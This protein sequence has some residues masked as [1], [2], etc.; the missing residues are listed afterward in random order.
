MFHGHG[1]MATATVIAAILAFS[2]AIV[3]AQIIGLLS[4]DRLSLL[5]VRGTGA[6]PLSMGG[7]Y[8]AVSDDA[9]AVFYNPAGLTQIGDRELSFGIHHAQSG[10]ENTY[11]GIRASTDNSST[12]FGHLAMVQP[13]SSYGNNVVFGLGVFRAATSDIEY[14][15]NAVRPDLGGTLANSLL[16]SGSIYQYRFALGAELT[17]RISAGAT[18]VLWN[19]SL[20]LKESISLQAAGSDS[21][22]AYSDDVSADLDGVSLEF[23]IMLWVT[24][25]IKAGVTMATP[26]KLYFDGDGDDSFTGTFPDGTPWTTD[27][28]SYYVEDE[29]TLP[30]KFAGGL[31]MEVENLL[32]AVDLSYSDYAQTEYN[33]LRLVD[34]TEPQRD[35]LE[36]VFGFCAG[37]E[38]TVPGTAVSLRG[39]YASMPLVL[40]GMEEMT[41]VID[42]PDNWGLATEYEFF[43]IRDDRRFY[44]FGIGGIID[45][46]LALDLALTYGK[47]ERETRFLTEKRDFTEIIV[48]GSYRF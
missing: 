10:I 25:F 5:D 18:L 13:V 31:A 35:V 15:R 6:R 42:E 1:K 20:D 21:S 29:F 30:M 41:Y 4:L 36:S 17:P 2:P 39:G 44:T 14:V 22:Y 46:A 38:F 27:D 7:A 19:E 9:F 26:A 16:Q 12:S 34:E 47:F 23:G 3:N 32:L 24:D 43:K 40:K 8:T 28:Q 33:D 45:E 11:E 48:S 37:A